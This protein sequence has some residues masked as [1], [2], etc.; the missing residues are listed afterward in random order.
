MTRCWEQVPNPE[1]RTTMYLALFVFLLLLAATC[2]GQS[3]QCHSEC[4]QDVCT[5]G[6]GRRLIGKQCCA[7]PDGVQSEKQHSIHNVIA[8]VSHNR[9][10]FPDQVRVHKSLILQEMGRVRALFE[11]VSS[12]LRAREHQVR[13]LAIAASSMHSQSIFA[14]PADKDTVVSTFSGCKVM[15][16][17]GSAVEII[18]DP[19]QSTA[20]FAHSFVTQPMFRCHCGRILG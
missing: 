8:A 13:Q 12:T 10:T 5:D 15:K 2:A 19:R 7:C 16:S 17:I 6:K 11:S 20:P 3:S 9:S 14:M 4:P 18:N 1:F